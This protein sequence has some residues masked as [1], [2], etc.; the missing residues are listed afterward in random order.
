MQKKN[1]IGLNKLKVKIIKRGKKNKW[2]KKDK[3]KTPQNYKSPMQMQRFI[4]PIKNVTEYTHIRIHP[5]AKSKQP[6]N[7]KVQQIDLLNKRNQRVYLPE[8]N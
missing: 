7:N 5:Q 1:I 3:R 6:N 2:K 8:Q 4:R